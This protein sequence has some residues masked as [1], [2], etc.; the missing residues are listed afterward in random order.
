MN[1]FFYDFT[2]EFP[3]LSS[4]LKFLVLG[5]I[6]EWIGG[7]IRT[8]GNLRT[9]PLKLLWGKFII[10]AILGVIIKWFFTSFILL[11][12]IHAES[13][14]LPDIFAKQGSLPFAF[15]V[16]L[17]MNLLFGPFLMYGHRFLDNLLERKWNW[18]GMHVPIYAIGWFWIPAH[19]I[20]FLLSKNFQIIFAA[21]LGVVLGIIL[22]FAKR[23]SKVCGNN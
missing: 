19:T 3:Y 1:W 12:P 21:F 14:L 23:E 4:A 15:M 17:Q 10:W 11:I 13:G 5:T 7:L 20:T 9:F 8:K 18:K 16:S 6:G 22:G 2:P